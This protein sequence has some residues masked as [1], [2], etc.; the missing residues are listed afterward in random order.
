MDLPYSKDGGSSDKVKYSLFFPWGAMYVHTL[1]VRRARQSIS[2]KLWE[3]KQRTYFTLLYFTLPYLGKVLQYC[4]MYHVSCIKEEK[5]VYQ[6]LGKA[7]LHHYYFTS[8]LPYL[9]ISTLPELK[10]G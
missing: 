4:I 9:F 10:E 8:S 6:L 2:G 5:G 7:L 3:L 1:L